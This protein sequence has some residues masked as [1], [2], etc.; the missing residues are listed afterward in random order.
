LNCKFLVGLLL[1]VGLLAG[2]GTSPPPV[3]GTS[4]CPTLDPHGSAA[5]ILSFSVI[6]VGRTEPAPQGG[7]QL[8]PEVYLRGPAMGGALVL[9]PR[10][11]GCP[12][13]AVRP[14]ERVLAALE[15]APGGWRWPAVGQLF[16]L[17][18]GRAEADDGRVMPEA[19]AVEAL[20]RT[21]GQLA[22]PAAADDAGGFDWLRG[23]LPVGVALAAV[24][25]LGLYLMRLWHRI[26][27]T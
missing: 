21:T 9:V 10:D 17:Q 6:V 23:G 8:R 14:G 3:V 27:P 25:G 7:L 13:A 16:V 26:D 15:P 4:G 11:D 1:A 22:Y 19:E 18:E 12:Q 24:F 2:G 20:R 5:D